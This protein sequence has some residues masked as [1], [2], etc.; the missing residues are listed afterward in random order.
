MRGQGTWI[1]QYQCKENVITLSSDFWQIGGFLQILR[2]L[3]HDITDML[4]SV[5]LNTRTLT[6]APETKRLYIKYI[7]SLTFKCFNVIITKI[8]KSLITVWF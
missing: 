8:V 5:T 1:Y 7:C 2:F 3:H 4:L 6:L